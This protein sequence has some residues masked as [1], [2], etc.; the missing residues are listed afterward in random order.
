M[1]GDPPIHLDEARRYLEDFP[2]IGPRIIYDKDGAW[3]SYKIEWTDDVK[4]ILHSS[5]L[6]R[7]RFEVLIP[8][9]LDG[10]LY[11]R[12]KDFLDRNGDY[13]LA[14]ISE[15]AI[16]CIPSQEA[17]DDL[18]IWMEEP[19]KRYHALTALSYFCKNGL[20]VDHLDEETQRKVAN[21]ILD[22]FFGETSS[23][24]LMY[25][26]ALEIIEMLDVRDEEVVAKSKEFIRSS[27]RKG[28]DDD[29]LR[30]LGQW[31]ARD[32]RLKK[33]LIEGVE[34]VMIDSKND[35]VAKLCKSFIKSI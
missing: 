17:M 21:S 30:K 32:P 23:D 34:D 18:L 27:L 20:E 26:Q 10:N 4:N 16:R 24:D 13:A 22:S 3:V 8:K 1:N 29:R 2:E 33:E 31:L 9:R 7:K 5:Y 11:R 35:R 19:E 12:Y 6:W 28:L 15:M 25:E 14:R